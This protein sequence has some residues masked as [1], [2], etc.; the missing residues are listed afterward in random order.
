[1]SKSIL[2]ISVTFPPR[3]SVASLRLYHYAKLFSENNW[4]VYVITASQKGEIKSNEFN[5]KNINITYVPWNDPFDSVMGLQN[6]YV[7]KAS[8]KLLSIFI[9][10]L[11]TW[12]PDR[13]FKSWRK[14]A[15]RIAE[16]LIEKKNI[17]Y[18]YSSYS[19]PSPHMIANKLKLKYK[20]LFWVSEFR[21]LMSFSHSNKW[22]EYPMALIHNIFEKK[23]L[24]NCDEILCVSEGHATLLKKYLG[25]PVNVLYNGCDFNAYSHLRIIENEKFVILYTGNV[26]RKRNNLDLFFKAVQDIVSTNEKNIEIVFIGTPKTRFLVNKIQKYQ[27][28][29]TVRFIEKSE[30]SL[31]KV[32]QKSAD[33]QLHFCW[34]KTAQIGNLTGKIF[35]YISARRPI[36]SVGKQEELKEII[37][38]T[39]SGQ[40]LNSEEEIKHFID[41]HLN[42]KQLLPAISNE[43]S[44]Y[45]KKH[46]FKLLE[47]RITR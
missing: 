1:M 19:P 13:R 42:S 21:D 40:I 20:N 45:S 32:Y 16:A 8:F 34:N 41:L 9:P 35:E 3:L 27:L 7:K 10:Y 26:Y 25:R 30:H 37:K 15:V 2:F 47:N 23:L 43:D 29:N 31:V 5:L 36:L 38:S 28:K 11:A 4:K 12:M 18:L 6:R 24:K 33:I 46:Q 17:K 14:N 44:I 22:Y 39:H